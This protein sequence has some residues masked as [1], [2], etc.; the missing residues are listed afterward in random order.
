MEVRPPPHCLGPP[1][2]QPESPPSMQ[3]QQDHRGCGEGPSALGRTGDA[4]RRCA[5]RKEP[6]ASPP[7]A[8]REV[9]HHHQGGLARQGPA[10]HSLPPAERLQQAVVQ[11]C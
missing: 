2:S 8:I 5:W 9:A 6:G 11:A 10:P 3:A 1:E 7:T 4:G